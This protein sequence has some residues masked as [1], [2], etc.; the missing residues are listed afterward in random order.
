MKLT[1][2][3]CHLLFDYE[4]CLD[5][6]WDNGYYWVES[7]SITNLNAVKRF[8]PYWVTDLDGVLS[9]ELEEWLPDR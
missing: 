5:I 4:S 8:G 3:S 6:D 1:K 2:E 7:I 9:E